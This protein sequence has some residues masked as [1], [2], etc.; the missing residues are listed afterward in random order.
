MEAVVASTFLQCISGIFLI[1][2]A[3]LYSQAPGLYGR[4]GILPI[5]RLLL[6]SDSDEPLKKFMSN[7]PT[8]LWFMPK[9]GLEPSHGVDILCIIGI[10]LAGA[11]LIWQRLRSSFS[12]FLLWLLYLSLYQVGQTFLWFQWDILLLET[13][14]LAIFVAPLFGGRPS[15]HNIGLWL[16]KWLLFRLMFASGV[17]KLTSQC[18]TWWGLTALDY[19]FE[20][21]CIPLPL[22]W[23]FHH[24][25]EWFRRLSVVATYVI[26]IAVPFFFFAPV[27]SLR[28]LSFWLQIIFQISIILTGNYNFFNLLTCVLCLPLLDDA[29]FE[30]TS[31]AE[32]PSVHGS[33]TAQKHKSHQVRPV[34]RLFSAVSGLLSRIAF[35]ATCLVVLYLTAV[36]FDIRVNTPKAFVETRVAFS[37]AEFDDALQYFMPLTIWIAVFSLAVKLLEGVVHCLRRPSFFSKLGALFQ[38]VLTASAAVYMFSISLIPHT[39]LDQGLQSRLWPVVHQWHGQS[40]YLHLTSSYGLFRRMTGVG[41]RPELILEGSYDLESGWKEYD[42][43]Y[44]PGNLSTRPPIVAPHQPRLDWQMW[45]A[46]LGSYHHNPWLISLV[47]RLLVGEPTVLDLMDTNPFPSRPPT[48]IRGTLYHYF[49]TKPSPR[50]TQSWWRRKEVKEYFPPVTKDEKTVHAFLDHHNL[51]QRNYPHQS[52]PGPLLSFLELV[53]EYTRLYSAP[54]LIAML[55]FAVAAVRLTMSPFASGL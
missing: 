46:A 45:F 42:F 48:Y 54:T 38:F 8:L 10:A 7:S 17:V 27:R 24:A 2:F 26:E 31:S 36:Y 39:V 22:A 9:L 23:Y 33:Q 4:N 6:L 44:K 1:A 5:H 16:V 55:F 49:F 35:L 13:G 43:L 14:F 30:S 47:E 51:R 52:Q 11:T 29:V 32:G 53:R 3:S 12:Y 41:G 25:P 37:M 50:G 34:S 15:S 18:P 19:H 21:Q 28:L 20:S 40:S